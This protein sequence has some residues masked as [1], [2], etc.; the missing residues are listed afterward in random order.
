MEKRRLCVGKIV[1]GEA[2]I[3]TDG[4]IKYMKD[5]PAK[6]VDWVTVRLVKEKSVLYGRRKISTPKDAMELV[7]GFLEYCDRE[8]L[9]VCSLDTKNQPTAMEV[10]SIGTVNSS[11]I[12]PR[13]IF[14]TSII[15][16]ASSLI[17]FHNHPS[18]DPKPSEEDKNIT[19]RLK[20]AGQI[21]GI[22]LL[23]HIIVA[24]DKFCSLKEK[25]IL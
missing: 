7:N 21:L 2:T 13:E 20:E 16:N 10:V 3:I 9:V 23:D 6:R 8:Q 14:K 15:S 4:G 22:E 24:D 12:H 19:I 11:L 5:R 18:G 1:N 25:G 17:V